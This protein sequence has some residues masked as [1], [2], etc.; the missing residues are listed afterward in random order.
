MLIVQRN[1]LT[2]WFAFCP[3]K[4]GGNCA[5]RSIPI[6]RMG[7]LD[8]RHHLQGCPFLWQRSGVWF[9]PRIF[10]LTF[11]GLRCK[12]WEGQYCCGVVIKQMLDLMALWSW[13]CKG[14]IK[15]GRGQSWKQGCCWKHQ[16]LVPLC[17][18]MSSLIAHVRHQSICLSI[19]ASSTQC[20][21]ERGVWNTYYKGWQTQNSQSRC[22][23]E[24][25]QSLIFPLIFS[26]E[27]NISVKK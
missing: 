4:Q 12:K 19:P 10:S 1:S 22:S 5:G 17:S 2:I 14:T 27:S 15:D 6:G 24:L 9:T 26:E 8:T 20:H 13:L 25:I 16:S 11:Q 7:F 21:R 3:K 18:T 23:R